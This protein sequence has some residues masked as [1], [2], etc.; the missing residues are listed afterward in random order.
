MPAPFTAEEA[1]QLG[2]QLWDLYIIQNKPLGEIANILNMSEPGIY[3]RLKMFAVPIIPWRKEKYLNTLKEVNIPPYSKELAEC[4][5]IILGDGNIS[6]TQ[7]RI[8]SHKHDDFLYHQYVKKLL[9][10]LFQIETHSIIKKNENAIE[11]Y[12][13]SAQVSRFLFQ[14]GL[15]KNKVKYQVMIP[16]WIFRKPEYARACLRGLIDT[17]G[18]IYKLRFGIQLSF[19]NCSKPLLEGV[20]K[21]FV[22]S[23]F[24]PSKISSDAVYLTRREELKR[25]FNEIGTS[26]PKHANRYKMFVNGQVPKW[27]TG[28]DCGQNCSLL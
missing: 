21:I 8:T 15:V 13:N 10:A 4:I 1:L 28:A 14:M 27:P 3:G 2:A 26:N 5:G 6:S 16:S 23:G 18:S 7:I 9:Q 11:C 20:R 12:M 22:D 17:D 25:Y 24:H 19:T